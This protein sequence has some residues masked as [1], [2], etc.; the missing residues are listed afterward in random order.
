MAERTGFQPS[1]SVVNYDMT[2]SDDDLSE[3]ES[4]NGQAF[5]YA[6]CYLPAPEFACRSS[7]NDSA[8]ESDSREDT[9]TAPI[10]NEPEAAPL[11]ASIPVEKPQQRLDQWLQAG[12]TFKVSTSGEESRTANQSVSTFASPSAK[13][14]KAEVLEISSQSEPE[15]EPAPKEVAASKRRPYALKAAVLPAEMR[16]FMA[17]SRRF[18]TRVHSLER[19]TAGVST[20]TYEKAEERMLCKCLGIWKIAC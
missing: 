15:E 3:I 7:E 8:T 14:I 20:S 5:V 9:K 18:H 19:S 16:D 17:A 2:S 6:S 11:P 1:V 13:G 12:R 10:I 4:A